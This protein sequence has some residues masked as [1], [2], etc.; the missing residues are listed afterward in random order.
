MAGKC[1]QIQ[2]FQ[3]HKIDNV[4]AHLTEEYQSATRCK[5]R[6]A[7]GMLDY[8]AA[9]RALDALLLELMH[10]NPS[11]ARSPEE[12]HGRDADDAS[13]AHSSQTTLPPGQRQYH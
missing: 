12:G 8:A 10:L 4:V 9:K 7:Y 6:N 13:P 2:R 5:M 3:V 11:A 1:A